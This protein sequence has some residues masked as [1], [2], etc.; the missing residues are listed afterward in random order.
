L[1]LATAV[2]VAVAVAAV[3]TT[4]AARSG[5]GHAVVAG[6]IVLVILAA[7]AIRYFRHAPRAY[8]IG[9]DALTFWDRAG[10]LRAQ[11]RITGCSQWSDMLL[12]LSL[13]EEGGRVHRVLVAADMLAPGAFRE[14][15]VLAR[16]S[17][18]L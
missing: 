3:C 13:A 1:Y 8:K 16:R 12:I 9:P 15:A 6:L 18:N 10:I 11:G 14:L 4:V 7:E 17:A 2:F 5:Q